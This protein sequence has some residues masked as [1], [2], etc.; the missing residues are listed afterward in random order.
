MYD[1]Q[2][3][4]GSRLFVCLAGFLRIHHRPA[5]DNTVVLT[6]RLC[7]GVRQVEG[8]EKK[9]QHTTH[10]A[11]RA[12]KAGLGSPAHAKHSRKSC[13]CRR[14]CDLVWLG[15]GWPC[16]GD[17]VGGEDVRLRSVVKPGR[18]SGLDCGHFW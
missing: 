12:S 8:K 9:L 13:E 14:G 6:R 5:L 4:S 18:K 3:G 1:H 11:M 2:A 7:T 10:H 15:T 16:G 17:P